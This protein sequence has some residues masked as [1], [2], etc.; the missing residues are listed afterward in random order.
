MLPRALRRP[1]PTSRCA[2][3]FSILAFA[4]ST[5]SKSANLRLTC[6][7]TPA[8]G[9]D[10]G[11]A[12]AGDSLVRFDTRL[13]EQPRG[14]FGG[15]D[16]LEVA[17][18][19]HGELHG[20]GL[21]EQRWQPFSDSTIATA[22]KICEGEPASCPSALSVEPSAS[23]A[24]PTFGATSIVLPPA[25]LT[26]FTSFWISPP[27]EPSAI[28]MPMVRPSI[29]AFM[30]FW[31]D[32]AWLGGMSIGARAALALRNLDAEPRRD[33][34]ARS[35]STLRRLATMRRRHLLQLDLRKFEHEG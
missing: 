8:S 16:R 35:S 21:L 4:A 15:A 28:R 31:I 3:I 6:V 34:R 24:L 19:V 25:A 14:R 29:V 18:G 32:R 12:Q 22:S 33:A 10:K 9:F 20:G 13:V 23:F 26:A 30:F 5:S 27:S 1:A 17:E 11:V 7:V 2:A